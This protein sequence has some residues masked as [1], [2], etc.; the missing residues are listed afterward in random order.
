MCEKHKFKFDRQSMVILKGKCVV[1]NIWKCICCGG[2]QII[3]KEECKIIS[4]GG[5]MGK[6]VVP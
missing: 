2:L 6:E 4:L 5:R 1:I 3:D